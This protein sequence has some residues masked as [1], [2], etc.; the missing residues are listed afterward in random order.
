MQKIANEIRQVCKTMNNKIL[1]DCSK[2]LYSDITGTMPCEGVSL[3]LQQL[4]LENC[5][6]SDSY[7]NM[8]RQNNRTVK[9]DVIKH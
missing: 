9:R 4:Y 1:Q 5:K 2:L 7:K 3:L 8:T 6:R